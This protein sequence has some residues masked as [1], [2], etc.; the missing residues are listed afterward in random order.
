MLKL[1][2]RDVGEFIADEL[3]AEHADLVCEKNAIQVVILM[4][5][6]AGAVAGHE[7]LESTGNLH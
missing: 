7:D 3:S 6:D 1:A 2:F 4:L 5:H